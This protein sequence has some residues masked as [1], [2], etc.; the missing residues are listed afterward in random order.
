LPIAD[1]VPGNDAVQSLTNSINQGR[2]F[3]RVQLQTNFFTGLSP[4]R[5]NGTNLVNASGAIVR[6]R[7]LNLGSWLLME[8]WMCP[9]DNSGSLPDHYSVLTNLDYRFGVA[10]EQNLM[11]IYQTN[12]ITVNDLNNITNGGYNCVRVP[13]WW[14]NF[15]SLTNTTSSGWRLDAFAQLDWLITNCTARGI[16]VVI[17]MHGVIGSQSTSQ[18]AGQQNL[19]AYWTNALCQSQTAWMWTQIAAHYFGNGTIA[20]YDLIN[21]PIGASNSSA[22]WSAYD[23]LYRAIRAVD[24]QR[25]IIM[26]GAF[27]SWNWSMLPNPKTYG[28]ANVA[29]SMH[30]YKFGGTTNQIMTGSDS[31]VTDFVNHLSWNV[32]AYVGE[33]NDMGSGA[34][35][36]DYSINAY[37]QAGISWSLWSYKA[38][39]GLL[40]N[41]W[42]WYDPT[43]WPTTPN[44]KTDSAATISADWQQ[45][46]TTVSFGKNS[47]VGL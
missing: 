25:L 47:S 40:P 18:T 4:L 22:V 45:W 7:G 1:F 29:Y 6:L 16:Y 43:Y 20:G 36:Y 26:E 24:P 37:D 11:R 17:D 41:G 46:K 5:A 8:K 39:Q 38:T 12:W 3:Y 21:E 44:I 32:P 42:G 15:F 28:W 23:S 30:E 31:Q 34:A 35:V 33:W 2:C 14:A 19:N 13:V 27:G 9:L 10:V